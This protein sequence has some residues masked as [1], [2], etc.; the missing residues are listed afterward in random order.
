LEELAKWVYDIQGVHEYGQKLYKTCLSE[1]VVQTCSHGNPFMP[2]TSL[3][4]VL[5]EIRN[6]ADIPVPK[7]IGPSAP[8]EPS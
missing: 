6:Y 7:T 2:S 3:G 4:C 8:R 1:A 5:L